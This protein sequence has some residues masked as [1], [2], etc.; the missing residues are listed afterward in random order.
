MKKLRF[1]LL[2]DKKALSCKSETTYTY[3]FNLVGTI[4]PTEIMP[5]S[6][7]MHPNNFFADELL[8]LE[9]QNEFNRHA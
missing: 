3:D 4:L 7:N 5:I 1:V 8:R 6:Y 9:C 2:R